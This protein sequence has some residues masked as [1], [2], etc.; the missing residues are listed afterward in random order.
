V[1]LE[2]ITYPGPIVD[3]ACPLPKKRSGPKLGG[4]AVRGVTTRDAHPPV[5]SAA[6]KLRPR[7][8]EGISCNAPF[9]GKWSTG[10]IGD[11]L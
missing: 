6:R 3:V 10:G 4:Q 5:F 7:W 8:A 1:V 2:P 11:C 9:V